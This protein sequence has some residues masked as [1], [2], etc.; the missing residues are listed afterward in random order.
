MKVSNEEKLNSNIEK[1]NNILQRYRN[2][3]FGEKTL[4][5]QEILI[6]ANEPNLLNEM[7]SSEVQYLCD[8]SSGMLKSMFL[9]LQKKKLSEEQKCKKLLKNIK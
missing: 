3:E 4:T 9:L 5:L 1:Y 8:H 6:A 7:T 2:G